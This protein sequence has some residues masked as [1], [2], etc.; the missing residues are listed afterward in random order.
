MTDLRLGFS[1][2]PEDACLLDYKPVTQNYNKQNTH[3]AKFVTGMKGMFA[4]SATRMY[5]WSSNK[6]A[7]LVKAEIAGLGGHSIVP[8][9]HVFGQALVGGRG[10]G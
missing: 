5:C 9:F 6:H 1:G 10:R 7:L 2:L 8:R 3:R 4:T